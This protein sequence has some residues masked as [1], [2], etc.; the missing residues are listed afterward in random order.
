MGA[1]GRLAAILAALSLALPAAS[2][3]WLTPPPHK[4]GRVVIDEQSRGAGLAPVVFEH[5]LHRAMYTCRLC[6][7]DIGFM[8]QAGKTGI[9]ADTNMQGY[10]CGA[11]H[12]GKKLRDGKAIF[13]ACSKDPGEEEKKRCERCHSQGKDVKNEYEYYSF[14][15]KLPRNASRF[16]DWEKAEAEGLVKPEDFV[17]GASFEKRAI[18]PREDFSIES[19][20][21]WMTDVIFSHKKH[22]AWNGC[23]V[24]HPEIFPSV[25]KGSLKYTMIEIADGQ[26]CGL[27]H[28]RV[29]FS[30]GEC[31]RCHPK[32]PSR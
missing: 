11:C 3:A 15:E 7:V 5:W 32:K 21:S 10:Y 18:K 19:K 30:L 8:M 17:E 4:Y 9:T 31:A 23:E 14:T 16:V 1:R 24:C 27:C 12:D 13:A 2:A 29:A 22:A 6:H 25:K 28:D 26:Y 20:A